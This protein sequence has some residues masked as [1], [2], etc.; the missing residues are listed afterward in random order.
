MANSLLSEPL[1]LE[2]TPVTRDGDLIP[3]TD[4]TRVPAWRQPRAWV[5]RNALFTAIVLVPTA[6]ATLYYGLIAADQYASEARFVVRSASGGGSL[7]TL[8]LG[9]GGGMAGGLGGAQAIS[10]APGMSRSPD[11]T[12]SV[13]EYIQSRDA[14]ERLVRDNGLREMLSRSEGDFINRFPNFY[15]ADNREK[16]YRHYLGFINVTVHS[17]TGISVLETRAFRPEDARD[18][19]RALLQH[20]EELVNR[21]NTRARGDAVRFAESVV[22]QAEERISTI[23]IRMTDFRNREMIVDP[24]KQ[25]EAALE[26]VSRL[27]GEAAIEKAQL[28]HLL[29]VAPSSPQIASLRS[30]IRSMDD[31]I[32]QQRAAV[33]GGDK[34]MAHKLSQ[35]EQIVLE[36]ELAVKSLTSALI[37]LENARQEA[38]RQQLYL[39]RVVEPNLPDYPSYPWRLLWIGFVFGL[40]LCI[41][42]IVRE[43]NAAVLE[44]RL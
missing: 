35:F 25:S 38:Q 44:H 30:R 10:S 23:Q 18:F 11:D 33:V 4:A 6:I 42:W 22:R 9:L 31:Q 26:L 12:Y 32:S 3:P 34:S 37:S 20:A 5:R 2:L 13:N 21:L 15:S 41:F 40:S 17:D 8:G 14:A 36:R 7:T 39:E 28:E 19:A 1:T 43:F 27:T 16:L 24:G 29:I